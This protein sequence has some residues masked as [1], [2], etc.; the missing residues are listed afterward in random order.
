[1]AASSALKNSWAMHQPKRTTGMLGASATTRVPTEPPARPITIQGRRMPH[2]DEVRSLRR[3]LRGLPN[4]A[5]REPTPATT[6]KRRG[7]CSIPTRESIF[8]ANVT[9]NG[10]ISRRMQ[11]MN[12]AVYRAIKVHLTRG[13]AANSV[14]S[15]S[16]VGE[17]GCDER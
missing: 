5:T 17:H 3:P 14:M 4:I 9:S 10:A 8:N 7:A 1:M 12:A 13:T 2:R 16:T 6:A 15:A 11:H